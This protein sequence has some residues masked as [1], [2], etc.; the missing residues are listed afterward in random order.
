MTTPN[1]PERQPQTTHNDKKQK[2]N[3]LQTPKTN[4]KKELKPKPTHNHNPKRPT[5]KTPN[6][7]FLLRFLEDLYIK[8]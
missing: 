5:N 4:N 8:Y 2:I 6:T 1:N 3:S 7:F